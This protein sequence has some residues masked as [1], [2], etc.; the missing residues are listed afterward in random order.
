MAKNLLR[1]PRRSPLD[2]RVRKLLPLFVLSASAAFAAD[3]AYTPPVGGMTVTI[4]GAAGGGSKVTTFTPSLRHAVSASFTG[5]ARGLLTG[6]TS[7]TLSD[8]SAGWAPSMLSQAAAPYFI[9]ILSGTASG[10]WWQISTSTANTST[11]VSILPRAGITAAA[12]GVAVGDKYEIIPADTLDILFSS[13]A[14]S[15]GGSS[16]TT[17]DTVQIHD[18]TSWKEYYYNTTFSQWREGTSSF[19][20][21]NVVIRPD[22]G[23]VFVR[24]Q[25][26]NL[27]L[28]LLGS[29]Q[30]SADRVIVPNTGVAFAANNFPV[31]RSLSAIALQS[32]PGFV[33]NSGTLAS[34]DKVNVF[35]GL[36]WRSFNFNAASGQWREGTSTFN[37]N[38]FLVPA[39]TPI[40]IE[41]GIAAA[42][43]SA[44][45]LTLT[46]P[47]T[48]P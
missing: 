34:A 15:I 47:Y 40:V 25:A 6:V 2:R 22:S 14:S 20:K 16:S 11:T 27:S 35:D 17:A 41:R 45:L 46:S 7:T 4:A 29:V 10:S 26:A 1:S 18:G 23:I 9:H 28:A 24:N 8:S 48:T 43:G 37:K 5:L 38:S 33:S 44:A 39:G 32:M 31:A 36:S 13:I 42:S 3:V 21:N 12:A 30:S 19:N